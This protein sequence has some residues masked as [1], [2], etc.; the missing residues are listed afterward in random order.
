MQLTG[1]LEIFRVQDLLGLVGRKPG[2]WLITLT[3]GP[4][5]HEAFIG[6]RDKRVVS[7]S[8]DVTRQDLARRLVIEGA[9]GTTGLAQALRHSSEN[10]LGLLRSL[11]DSDTVD[12][13][14]IPRGV[15]AHAV[16]AL[17]SLAH[18]RSGTFE[19]DVVDELPDD[20]GVSF[21]LSELG[22][23]VVEILKRWRPASDLLGGA[24]TVI[25][26]Y[27]GA[28]PEHLL[29]LHSLIDGH[30][31]VGE[32]IEA[33]GHGEIGTVVDLADLVDAG[34]AIPMTGEMGA[35]EQR[36]A[37]LSALEQPVSG[38]ERT[39]RERQVP[40][41]S[42]IPGGAA[43]THSSPQRP[44]AEATGEDLLAALLKAVRGV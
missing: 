1:A 40:N 14:V 39:E 4:R 18:W 31:T 24:D 41:L 44:P 20:V 9:I 3:G 17:A 7:V 36:L 11:A 29:G 34:C 30:R 27:P 8:A 25:G 42:V 15:R 33:S 12:P 6:L 16:S 13:S 2:Q 19:V 21:A 10:R 38:G 22:R 5:G 37:M 23:E 32:L 26:A 28:I 43:T 35:L